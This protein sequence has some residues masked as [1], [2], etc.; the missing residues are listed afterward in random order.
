MR[1]ERGS[2]LI[3]VILVVLVLT[4]VGIASLFFMTTEDRISGVDRNEK[5]TLYGAESGLRQAEK[6]AMEDFSLYGT[7]SAGTL[8]AKGGT[9]IT[10]PGGG[11]PAIPLVYDPPA[12][13]TA[14]YP[15]TSSTF[16]NQAVQGFPGMTTSLYI[17]NNSDDPSHSAT[18][19]Q[20]R[21]VNLVV[22]AQ[23]QVGTNTMQ[24]IVE[25]QFMLGSPSS[26]E[27]LQKQLN[28]GGTGTA[29]VGR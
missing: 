11:Y 8:L 7:A 22:I 16:M 14:G 18:V 5:S 10:L 20:D 19:D 17:R 15:A 4:M 26:G 21:L 23:L 27:S 29:V 6:V 2:A 13:G 25:E 1:N 3:T 12:I 24:K 9:A 28:F